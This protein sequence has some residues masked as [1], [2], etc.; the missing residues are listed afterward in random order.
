MIFVCEAKYSVKDKDYPN[1]DNYDS[2]GRIKERTSA[3]DFFQAVDY[4]EASC[5]QM[6][7]NL[8]GL[9]NYEIVKVYWDEKS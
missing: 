5:E 8:V 9:R 1:D 2:F 3:K 7:G 4:F 6:F